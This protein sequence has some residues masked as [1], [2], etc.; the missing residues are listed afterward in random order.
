VFS[1]FAKSDPRSCSLSPD[2]VANGMSSKDA[3]FKWLSPGTM[4]DVHAIEWAHNELLK[5]TK[6]MVGRKE[7]KAKSA[8]QAPLSPSPAPSARTAL[9]NESAGTRSPLAPKNCNSPAASNTASK[10][11]SANLIKSIAK[12]K[13]AMRPLVL[14]DGAEWLRDGSKQGY[15]ELLEDVKLGLF[16]GGGGE[17][18]KIKEDCEVNPLCLPGRNPMEVKEEWAAGVERVLQCVVL[19]SGEAYQPAMR[20]MVAS[21]LLMFQYDESKAFWTMCYAS[22]CL[23][24]YWTPAMEGIEVD[25]WIIGELM[26]DI[27]PDLHSHLEALGLASCGELVKA[28]LS[29]GMASALDTKALRALWGTSFNMSH[30]RRALVAASVAVLKWAEE[31]ILGA[32]TASAASEVLTHATT[33]C[34]DA[35]DFSTAV[36]I[37]LEAVSPE[38]YETLQAEAKVTVLK[39]ADKSEELVSSKL[40]KEAVESAPEI[41]TEDASK[42]TL[43]AAKVGMW[44]SLV[45]NQAA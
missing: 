10:D 38:E 26:Q 36:D 28:S 19:R 43:L 9:F 12:K 34:L 4:G 39:A 30:G 11:G 22:N 13:M 33:C 8:T 25:A 2:A 32:E 14:S 1:C 21:L 35:A 23:E 18:L 17:M 37:W 6:T 45:A 27:T 44:E 42:Q 15:E 29:T 20:Q 41:S 24:G 31:E 7:L 16:L 5:R 3:K 40:K